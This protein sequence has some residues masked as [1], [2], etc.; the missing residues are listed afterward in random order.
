MALSDKL[1]DRGERIVMECGAP[2]RARAR[3]AIAAAGGSVKVA[4]VMVRAGIGADEARSR[5]AAAGGS[6]RK[7]AGD[8]PPIRS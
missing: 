2:D 1:E 7:A 4:V 6:V 8:P 3:A 5:L